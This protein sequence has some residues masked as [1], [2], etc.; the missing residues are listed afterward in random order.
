MV[1]VAHT[2]KKPL[3]KHLEGDAMWFV[4]VDQHLLSRVVLLVSTSVFSS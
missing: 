4:A 3:S 1:I 2:P